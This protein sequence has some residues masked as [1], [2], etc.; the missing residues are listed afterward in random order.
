[1][2][3]LLRRP[4]TTAVRQM[5]SLCTC[6]TAAFRASVHSAVDT[7]RLTAKRLGTEPIETCDS[8]PLG[9]ETMPHHLGSNTQN[10]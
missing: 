2:Y 8:V 6:L 9:Q 10:C 5:Q 4:R 1:M 7:L 3:F